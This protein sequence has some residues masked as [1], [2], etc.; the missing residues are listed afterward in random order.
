MTYRARTLFIVPVLSLLVLSG[1][2]YWNYLS[3]SKALISGATIHVVYFLIAAIILGLFAHPY[4][5]VQQR[6]PA[7]FYYKEFQEPYHTAPVGLM[8][9]FNKKEQ[10]LLEKHTTFF[11]LYWDNPYFLENQNLCRSVLGF[12]ITKK[13]RPDVVELLLKAGLRQVDFPRWTAVEASMRTIT[14]VT[15]AIA[16]M[17]LIVPI[18]DLVCEKYPDRFGPMPLYEVCDGR[19]STYGFVVDESQEL[20]RGLTPFPEPRM[21]EEGQ[22]YMAKKIKDKSN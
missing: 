17:K 19:Y 6:G 21:N 13:V 18:H 14:E 9:L 11:G 10:A 16:P 20:F 7:V 2:F 3:L 15:C 22:K 5:R 12:L 8:S 1:L 4:A